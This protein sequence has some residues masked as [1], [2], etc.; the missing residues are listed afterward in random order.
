[1]PENGFLLALEAR[2]EVGDGDVEK[3]RGCDG[4][5]VRNP[6]ERTLQREVA[7]DATEKRRQAGERIPEQRAPSFPTS[8][9][10]N[11]EIPRFLRDFMGDDGQC[12]GPAECRVGEEG[13]SDQET[14]SEIV[15]GVPDE[16]G[17]RFAALAMMVGVGM[18]LAGML[19]CVRIR[20]AVRM[21]PE[22]E[23]FE[24][25]KTKNASEEQRE[26]LVRA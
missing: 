25:K 24:G 16:D 19:V 9:K 13:S 17:N 11:G 5:D 10:Q 20:C 26:D 23:F 4:Q 8:G 18:V 15:E 12:G 1:M 14:V 22:R 3:A 7:D 6:F 21:S 2:H